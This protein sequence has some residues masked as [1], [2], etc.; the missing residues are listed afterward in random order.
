MSR[1]RSGAFAIALPPDDYLSVGE[2]PWHRDVWLPHRDSRLLH[3]R[4]FQR[5]AADPVGHG[6][7]V[8]DRSARHDTLHQVIEPP[9]IEDTAIGRASNREIDLERLG[10]RPLVLENP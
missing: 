2:R 8:V 6:L 10:H 7:E 1:V 9:V 5:D 3:S 4:I